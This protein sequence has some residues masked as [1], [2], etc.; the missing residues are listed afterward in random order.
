MFSDQ[1]N[2]NSNN[3]VGIF[4][5]YIF[6]FRTTKHIFLQK[7]E[8]EPQ[9]TEEAMVRQLWKLWKTKWGSLK[10]GSKI[11]HQ[12][13]TPYKMWG[14]DSELACSSCVLHKEGRNIGKL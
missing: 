3:D 8:I 9:M 6:S 12:K 7:K 2:N 4:Q 14:V 1:K 10:H 11:L 5:S 13:K